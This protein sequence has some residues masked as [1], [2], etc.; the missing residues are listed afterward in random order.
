MVHWIPVHTLTNSLTILSPRVIHSPHKI[1][2]RISLTDKRLHTSLP[3]I[4]LSSHATLLKTPHTSLSFCYSQIPHPK[5]PSAFSLTPFTL[6][7]RLSQHLPLNPKSPHRHLHFLPSPIFH[8]RHLQPPKTRL[9]QPSTHRLPSSTPS[10]HFHKTHANPLR[11]APPS[12]P[13]SHST[14]PPASPSNKSAASHHFHRRN[15]N[16]PPL[17]PNPLIRPF[18]STFT[19]TVPWKSPK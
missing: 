5:K 13:S 19:F 11:I 16:H 3:I 2:L 18:K 1:P 6:L 17:M 10:N 14:L 7:H 15:G 4:P 8:F 9:H 12:K